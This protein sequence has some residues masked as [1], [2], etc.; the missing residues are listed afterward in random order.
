MQNVHLEEYGDPDYQEIRNSFGFCHKPLG[1][2]VWHQ[3]LIIT[4][5]IMKISVSQHWASST[6]IIL[7]VPYH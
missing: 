4:P 5:Q 2:V 3:E 6:A 1:I 7:T